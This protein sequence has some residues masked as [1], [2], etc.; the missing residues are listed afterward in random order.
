MELIFPD[1]LYDSPEWEEGKYSKKLLSQLAKIDPEA[2]V[3]DI[4][5]GHGAGWPVVL[6]EIFKGVDW[7]QLFTITSLGGI[8]LLGK[9]INEN[10]DAWIE[11]GKKFIKLIEK[12]KPARVDEHAAVLFIISFCRKMEKVL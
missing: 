5:I 8:F 11:I 7:S 9:K 2:S 1:A 12:I 4:D 10:I 3:A 6:V